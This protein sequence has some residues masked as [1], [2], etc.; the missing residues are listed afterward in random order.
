MREASGVGLRLAQCSRPWNTSTSSVEASHE[1]IYP[2]CAG[3]PDGTAQCRSGRVQ[4]QTGHNGHS[5]RRASD[6]NARAMQC[7][8]VIGAMRL[9]E[10]ADAP[11]AVS[12][13]ARTPI[14]TSCSPAAMHNAITNA[15]S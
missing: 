9:E 4:V 5:V 11:V 1:I 12:K 7:Y 15:A 8:R 10:S 2:R 3:L 14:A 6:Y 13:A